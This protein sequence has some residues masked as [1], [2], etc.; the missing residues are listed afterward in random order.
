MSDLLLEVGTE[1]L[2]AGF[3]SDAIRQWEQM[4][5]ASLAAEALTSEVKVYAPP[6][7]RDY[8]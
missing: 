3:I 4:I 5:P 1:D 6:S 2:P 7:V 8:H